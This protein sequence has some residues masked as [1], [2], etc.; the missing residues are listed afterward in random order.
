MDRREHWNDAWTKRNPESVSWYQ[1][2]P[3]PSLGLIRAVTVKG[4]RVVDVGGGASGLAGALVAA[5]YS[6]VTVLDVSAAALA[7]LAQR[8]GD[9]APLVRTVE[10]DVLE[11]GFEPERS[12]ERRVGKECTSWCRSRWSPYH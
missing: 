11:H 1:A 3:E 2:E 7:T 12:E 10:A 4:D 5:G 8:L 9:A 6:D